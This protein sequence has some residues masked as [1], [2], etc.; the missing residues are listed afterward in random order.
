MKPILILLASAITT[1]GMA[2]C[3]STWNVGSYWPCNQAS[4][5]TVHRLSGG[6]PPFQITLYAGTSSTVLGSASGVVTD[7]PAIAPITQPFRA[8]ITDVNGCVQTVYASAITTAPNTTAPVPT[9]IPVDPETGI[10]GYSINSGS[11]GYTGTCMAFRIQQGANIILSKDFSTYWQV[12]AFSGLVPGTYSVQYNNSSCSGAYNSNW[13]SY[14]AIGTVPT[15]WQYSLHEA[16][17]AA[18]HGVTIPT[19]GPDPNA[20][21][22]P[23]KVL[24]EGPYVQASGLMSDALR[25]NDQLPWGITTNFYLGPSL[26]RTNT[27]ANMDPASRAVTGNNAYVDWLRIELRDAANPATIV[28]SRTA[29]VQR[30]GD[31]VMQNGTGPLSCNVAAGS[32]YVVVKHRNHLGIMTAAP[33]PLGLNTATIDFTSPTTLTYG[34]NAQKQVG[35]KMVMW[36]GDAT[37]DGTVQ[38][39][40]T[41]N[42]RDPILSKVGSNTPNNTVSNVYYTTDLNMDGLVR[43]TGTANDRDIILLNVGSTTPNNTRTQQLP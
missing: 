28:Y 10:G 32:Y 33:V 8:V 17:C 24:L 39:T 16:F 20:V 5:T 42:D 7:Y 31:V 38:Y 43:Y 4:W 2:Q 36:A 9:I 12:S 3:G 27:I 37:G 35:T 23:I 11:I 19:P 22:L 6:A 30:D 21:R 18:A 13:G 14:A 26:T 40:G 15:P 34:T 41:N 25:A 1:S 29:L